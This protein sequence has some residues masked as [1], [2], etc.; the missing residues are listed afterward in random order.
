[1]SILVTRPA[2][3]GEELV[4]RLQAAG[5]TAFSAPLINIHPGS[6]LP[7]LAE[8]L[9]P[10]NTRDMVFLLSKNAVYYANNQLNKINL[11]W[12]DKLIYY[13]IGRSTAL[14]FHQLT[15]M[16]VIWSSEGET[17]EILLK[18]PS[19]HQVENKQA[20]LLRGNGGRELI[21]RTLTERGATV[22]YCECYFRQP[23]DYPAAEF[24]AHWQKYGVQTLVVTSGEILQLL[25]NLI[26]ESDRNRWLL[27]CRL[28]VVSE[29]LAHAARNL[30]WQDVK[31]A[32]S[33]DNDALIQ[34][35]E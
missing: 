21:A 5:K 16:N 6:E 23:V 17:S 20:L 29:R 1:M 12:P 33:A 18:L 25:Y 2:P 8:K 4:R 11:S 14:A 10:L 15:G 26:P 13:A 32:K 27:H 31:V 19:L 22:D 7:Q 28:I 35:L 3:A 24:S 30:G 9:N 34:A